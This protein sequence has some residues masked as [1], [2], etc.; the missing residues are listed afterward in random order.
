MKDWE[1]PSGEPSE[2]YRG[3]VEYINP[4]YGHGHAKMFCPRCGSTELESLE[5]Y[6]R[7]LRC[8]KCGRVFELVLYPNNE[9][10]EYSI[11][12]FGEP[13]YEGLPADDVNYET[14]GTVVDCEDDGR[15]HELA[16][17]Y[18]GGAYDDLYS[19]ECDVMDS[20]EIRR[21]LGF[22]VP[23]VEI[24]HLTENGYIGGME[25]GDEI[26]VP[27][28]EVSIVRTKN[29]KARKGKRSARLGFRR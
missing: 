15:L 29:S 9:G 18:Y 14:C 23:F 5:R 12:Y 10:R 20:A 28:T 17:S 1:F 24:N 25:V 11:N 4:T 22:D 8:R 6:D 3:P 27:G 16:S 26:F 21:R 19:D 7:K 2:F 13:E